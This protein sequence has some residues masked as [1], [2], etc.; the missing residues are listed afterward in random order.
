MLIVYYENKIYRPLIRFLLLRNNTFRTG[1]CF[2]FFPNNK[3]LRL[4]SNGA[5]VAAAYI[6]SLIYSS[7]F[8][9][10]KLFNKTNWTSAHV[11]QSSSLFYIIL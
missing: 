3:L 9:L 7:E 8:G 4:T 6:L 1:Y 11:K 10:S 5:F 2:E